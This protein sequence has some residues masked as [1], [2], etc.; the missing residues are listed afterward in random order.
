MSERQISRKE[1]RKRNLKQNKRRKSL[2]VLLI[3]AV[4][5]VLVY[6]TG[7]YGT[8]LA[9][10]GDFLSN[11]MA[12]V[13]IGDGWPVENDYSNLLQA[14]GMG[15]GLCVLTQDSLLVYSPTGKEI[16][17]YSHSMQHPVIATSDNRV[18]FYDSNQTMLKV[19]NSHNVLFQQEMGNNI[20]HADISGS[21]RVAV[22][23]RSS[24][25]DGEVTV[26]NY[27][28][29]ERMTWYCAT[30]YPVYSRLSSNGN[31]L[32]VEA[33]QTDNGLFQS[34]IYVI[35]VQ[36]GQEKFTL[37]GGNYPVDMQFISND[38]LLVIYTNSMGLY[39]AGSGELLASYTFGG[40][41]IKA[42]KCKGQYIAVAYGAY[43]MGNSTTLALL[44]TKL[45]EKYTAHIQDNIKALSISQSRVFA[46]GEGNLYEYNYSLEPV[47]TTGINGFAK[48][49]VSY[50]GTTLIDSTAITKVDK[51]RS[52]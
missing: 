27:N 40:D 35:D 38:K 6:I 34:Q 12:L 33:V 11:G 7:I 25:Y 49:L 31:L 44:S 42:V 5:A 4:T 2:R 22:T 14:D 18:V 45:E 16:F 1:L 23:T 28:M 52:N 39:D 47:N 15:T 13:Q 30:G 3:V 37:V 51:T 10:L 19:A 21:N 20:V 8:S 29:A 48:A 9:Y 24:S 36:R 26:F 50:N 46:M 43:S 17:D 32:A 41:F